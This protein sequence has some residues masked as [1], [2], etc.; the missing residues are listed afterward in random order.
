MALI[1]AYMKSQNPHCQYYFISLLPKFSYTYTSFIM[2]YSTAVVG[3]LAVCVS[4]VAAFPAAAIEYAAKAQRDAVVASEIDGSIAKFK[5]TRATPGFNAT[6]QYVS[7]SGQYTFVAPDL[8]KDNRGPCPGLNAMANHGYI[9]HNGVATI[10]QFID[11][12]Y[13]SKL[14]CVPVSLFTFNIL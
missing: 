11:G 13:Q 7:T 2:K 12:T 4:E 3:A 1:I 14:P 5:K 9:P 8:T 10:Q 6:A